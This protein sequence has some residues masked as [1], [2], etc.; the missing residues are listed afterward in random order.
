M[1]AQERRDN[2]REFNEIAA[3]MQQAVNPT[4]PVVAEVRITRSRLEPVPGRA[5]RVAWRWIYRYSVDGAPTVEYGTSL[6]S[7]R[8]RLHRKFPT[9]KIVKD[10]EI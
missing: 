2:A 6:A 1:D 10:W 5:L 4:S 8:E 9:A 3:L 7:L